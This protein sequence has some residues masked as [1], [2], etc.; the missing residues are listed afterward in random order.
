MELWF[1]EE[2]TDNI[3]FSIKAD[4][5]LYSG[6]SRFQR[7]DVFETVEVG[8]L[9]VIDGWIMLTEKDE[10]V[11]HEMIAHV[12]M[13]VHPGVKRVLVVGGGD[14]GA[15]RELCRYDTIEQIDLVEIDEMVV[16]VCRREVPQLRALADRRMVA[17]HRADDVPLEEAA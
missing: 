4:K 14:G 3:R 16:A 11:Y 10:F 5:Q 2:N 13:A 1:T 17:C 8:R 15:V 12:P 9:L 7:I 6:Q